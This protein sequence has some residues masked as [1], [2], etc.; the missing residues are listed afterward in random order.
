MPNNKIKYQNSPLSFDPHTAVAFPLV[1]GFPATRRPGHGE[2]DHRMRSPRMFPH[3]N[4]TCPDRGPPLHR[5]PEVSRCE[6]TVLFYLTILS[7]LIASTLSP[8]L[9]FSWA[10]EGHMLCFIPCLHQS[11]TMTLKSTYSKPYSPTVFSYCPRE[12]MKG[13]SLLYPPRPSHHQILMMHWFYL[14][15]LLSKP[16]NCFHPYC[17]VQEP[18]PPSWTGLQNSASLHFP[19]HSPHLQSKWSFKAEVWL[20]QFHKHMKHCP[21]SLRMKFK[22]L[23]QNLTSAHLSSFTWAQLVLPARPWTIHSNN[24]EYLCFLEMLVCLWPWQHPTSTPPWPSPWCSLC[25]EY[26][27]SFQSWSPIIPIHFSS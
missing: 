19:I 12:N 9:S 10:L 13:Y 4:H 23:K 26:S 14:L 16:S 1:V 7:M 11:P 5:P 25:L 20:W 6:W 3:F 18:S 8:A 2:T 24:N 15:K 17:C 27:S 22:S 21:T